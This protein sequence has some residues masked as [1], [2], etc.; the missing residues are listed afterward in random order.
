MSNGDRRDGSMVKTTDC[1]RKGPAPFQA[2]IQC[3]QLPVTPVQRIYRYLLTSSRASHDTGALKW[4]QYIHTHK[5]EFFKLRKMHIECSD[6]YFIIDDKLNFIQVW[7][8]SSAGRMPAQHVQSQGFYT[9]AQIKGGNTALGSRN[10]RMRSLWL[11]WV[12]G[13]LGL[14]KNVCMYVCTN[15]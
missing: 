15:E 3:Y 12:G 7:Y 2:P 11:Y 4:R 1:S 10:R 13:F 5:V 9:E 14:H 8:G 6:T